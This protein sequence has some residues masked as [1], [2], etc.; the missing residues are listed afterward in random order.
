[1]GTIGGS[2]PLKKLTLQ[3]TGANTLNGDINTTDDVDLKGT[4]RTT[5]FSNADRSI[6]TTNS[7]ANGAITIGTINSAY[8]LT[9]NAGSGTITLG[10]VGDETPLDTLTLTGAGA[11]ALVGGIMTTGNIDL[12]TNRTTA[13]TADSTIGSSTGTLNIGAI[14]IA[15]AKTLTLGLSG[16]GNIT[17]ASVTGPSSGTVANVTFSNS[18]TVTVTGAISTNIGTLWLNKTSGAVSFAGSLQVTQFKTDTNAAYNIGLTGA[19][20]TI[21][22]FSQA[23][24]FATSGTLTIGDEVTDSF[25]YS[26]GAFAPTSP[27]GITLAGSIITS[28]TTAGAGSVTLGDANTTLAIT[29]NLTINTS[30]NRQKRWPPL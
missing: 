27:S 22:S 13:V 2:T 3:G 7:A 6:T 1:L 14:T 18:G 9:L 26:G 29:T 5:T 30:P 25:T 17:V 11:N 20:N 24:A 23:S 28:S 8:G 21:A 10:L 12:G 16:V 15:A 19:S 4:S